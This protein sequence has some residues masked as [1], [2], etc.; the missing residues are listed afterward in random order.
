MTGAGQSLMRPWARGPLLPRFGLISCLTVPLAGC[1][2]PPAAP[3]FVFFGSYFPAWIVCAI[4]GVVVAVAVRKLFIVIGLDEALP[5]RLIVY[6]SLALMAA[7]G[8]W[9]LWFGG[10]PG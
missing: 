3:T 8:L 2:R 7:V 9:S 10:S 1:D 5:V 6:A 4:L